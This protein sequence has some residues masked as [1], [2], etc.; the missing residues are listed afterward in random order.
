VGTGM[1]IVSPRWPSRKDLE[2]VSDHDQFY[3]CY[4]DVLT[5]Y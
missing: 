2:S 4:V 1:L 3:I 5:I